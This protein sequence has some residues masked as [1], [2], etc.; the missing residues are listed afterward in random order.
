MTWD[1]LRSS[2]YISTV[3]RKC[4]YLCVCVCI[5]R[6]KYIFCLNI[7]QIHF[8]HTACRSIIK[9]SSLNQ[10]VC[11]KIGKKSKVDKVTEGF[12]I[13]RSYVKS[14]YTHVC[15]YSTTRTYT[16]RDINKK[17]VQ[18]IRSYYSIQQNKMF[19]LKTCFY[20]RLEIDS[21]VFSEQHFG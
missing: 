16:E 19:G 14:P 4:F 21:H 5:F 13:F 2:L 17:P 8:G 15:C 11:S 10:P 1:T 20:T 12:S 6:W 18:K 7:T 3:K 9:F